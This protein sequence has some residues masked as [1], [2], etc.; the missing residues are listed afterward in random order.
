MKTILVLLF[1]VTANAANQVEV[2]S[3]RL[4]GLLESRN[5]KV[6]ISK[7]EKGSAEVR[8]G[9]LVR[10]FLPAIEAYGGQETFKVG[11]NSQRS[12]PTYGIEA[13]VNVYRGGRDQIENEIRSLESGKKEF[14]ARRIFSEELEKARLAYWKLL[15]LKEK[16]T[17]TKSAI[18]TNKQ[19]LNSAKRRIQSGVA[20]LSDRF[21]FEMKETDLQ[22]I[23]ATNTIEIQAQSRLLSLILGL[24]S[25][26]I[27]TTTERLQHDHEFES[28]LKHTVTDHEFL[29]KESQLVSQQRS[30]QAQSHSRA[31]WPKVDVF[32][33]YNQFNERDKEFANSADRT[34]SV[35]GVRATLSL[36]AGLESGREASAFQQAAR[37]AEMESK[38][39]QRELEIHLEAETAELKALHDQ[40]H[41]AEENIER[42]ER[43]YKMTLSEYSRGVKN[44]PDVLGASEK[45]FDIQHRRL[46]IVRDFQIAKAHIL[47]KIGK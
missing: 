37:A 44:S 25:D 35:V 43:Y 17:L 1:S 36:P 9:Y 8:E 40:V 28:A 31:W 11:A 34:D 21:E 38:Y 32:G 47:S 7:L 5:T 16:E 12:Q 46:E 20:T 29:F 24:E 2:D 41:Q 27:I 13:R 26:Q 18:E 30:L 10:S 19:N 22:R 33:A 39:Q 23:L 14:Q 42:A 3:N 15:Y 4:K 45:L 6:Q